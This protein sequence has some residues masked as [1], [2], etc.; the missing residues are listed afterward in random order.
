MFLSLPTVSVRAQN[1][2]CCS[3]VECAGEIGVM[4]ARE[5]CVDTPNGLAYHISAMEANIVCIGEHAK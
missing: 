1:V 5:C 4:S 3:D 2:V